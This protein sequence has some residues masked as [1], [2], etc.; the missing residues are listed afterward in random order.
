MEESEQ[1][2]EQI[3]LGEAVERFIA[4]PVIQRVFSDLD[5]WY[6]K[7]W[8]EEDD[9]VREG[10]RLEARALDRLADVLKGV[11]EKGVT[12]KRQVEQRSK[13]SIY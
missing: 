9:S 5:E 2:D 3:R 11:A 10:Y 6:Y 4:D 7:K 13:P 12:A 8:K 1:L